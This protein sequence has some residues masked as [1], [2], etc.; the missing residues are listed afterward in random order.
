MLLIKVI[1]WHKLV[2]VFI[3]TTIH[4]F[5]TFVLI[6]LYVCAYSYSKMAS[7]DEKLDMILIFNEWHRNSRQAAQVTTVTLKGIPIVINPH[8]IIFH[9]LKI[10]CELMVHLEYRRPIQQTDIEA[11]E[12]VQV[13]VLAC[14]QINLVT[15]FIKKKRDQ[16]F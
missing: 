16:Q 14:V 2:L 5:S 6:F 10:K 3:W 9:G 15:I 11:N 4:S 7:H 8:I 13:W 12:G 1:I